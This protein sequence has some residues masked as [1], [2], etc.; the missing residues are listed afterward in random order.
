MPL[1]TIDRFLGIQPVLDDH[2]LPAP[3]AADASN[4]RLDNGALRALMKPVRDA[5]AV[6]T[7]VDHAVIDGDET[8]MTVRRMHARPEFD[9]W[10]LRDHTAVLLSNQIADELPYK[11]TLKTTSPQGFG[12]FV[13]TLT[14]IGDIASMEGFNTHSA[15]FPHTFYADANSTASGQYAP[16][17]A[18][19]DG[20]EGDG[21]PGPNSGHNVNAARP[22]YTQPAITQ[23]TSPLGDGNLITA[24]TY[25]WRTYDWWQ[26]TD[27]WNHMQ[28]RWYPICAEFVSQEIE[29]S[30]VAAAGSSWT[31]T[32]EADDVYQ[33][34][35]EDGV[36]PVSSNADFD[37]GVV[38]VEAT[39]DIS[40]P[41]KKF[42][43]RVRIFNDYSEWRW[44][45]STVTRPT[46]SPTTVSKKFWM[47]VIDND[48]H[49]DDKAVT[50]TFVTDRF[51][52]NAGVGSMPGGGW[53][54][55][56]GGGGL[57]E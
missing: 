57:L 39:G 51:V 18:F 47:R 26:T 49:T 16:A 2:L 42:K 46:D 24:A 34:Y 53:G 17:C 41:W 40:N 32:T 48:L 45:S 14:P 35:E 44:Y 12:Q 52:V 10:F 38:T 29:V 11:P 54:G 19:L 13:V 36:T 1:L 7:G 43:A 56:I 22:T 37:N 9:Q 25:E 50:I 31:N 30:I 55:G 23:W 4:A 5:A 20:H 33:L 27:L 15:P 3:N 8:V 21:I 6:N 28:L